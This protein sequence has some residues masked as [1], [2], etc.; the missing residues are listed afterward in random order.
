MVRDAGSGRRIEKQCRTAKTSCQVP[1]SDFAAVHAI[2]INAALSGH[3]N[4]AHKVQLLS[5]NG[6]L[7]RPY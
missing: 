2:L 1:I 5:Q 7:E 6:R 3:L 4:D